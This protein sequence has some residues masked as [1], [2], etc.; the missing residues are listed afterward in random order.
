MAIRILVADDHKFVTDVME[1][2]LNKNRDIE[3]IG[4]SGTGEDT[5]R[6]TRELGPDVVVL[7]AVMPGMRGSEAALQI[8]A[9]HSNVKVLAFS[10]YSKEYLVKDMLDAGVSGFVLKQDGYGVLIHAIKQVHAG[11]PYFSPKIEDIIIRERLLQKKGKDKSRDSDLTARER[12]VLKM[13][14]EGLADR[15]IS[16][17]LC[18]SVHAVKTHI[19]NIRAKSNVKSRTSLAIYAIRTDLVSLEQLPEEAFHPSCLQNT[20]PFHVTLLS[21]K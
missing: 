17:R 14:V 20:T 2:M 8:T 5:V 7:D 11:V 1:L 12:E 13:I 18:M 10:G 3:M 19:K 15:E 6:L 4:R 21:D 16:K 9:E